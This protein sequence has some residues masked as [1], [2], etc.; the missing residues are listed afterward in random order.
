MSISFSLFSNEW[1]YFIV[2]ICHLYFHLKHVVYVMYSWMYE[3][4]LCKFVLRC[5]TQNEVWVRFYE[6][7]RFH[8]RSNFANI[9][10]IINSFPFLFKLFLWHIF[11]L[12]FSRFVSK[13]HFKSITFES[14]RWQIV[15][16]FIR[17]RSLILSII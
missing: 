16:N 14:L 12:Y 5:W 2:M 8:N 11:I 3:S 9:I 7:S 10:Q 1:T 17:L 15:S 13:F 6:I 4:C